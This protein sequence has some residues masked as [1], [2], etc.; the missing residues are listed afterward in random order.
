MY[1]VVGGLLMMAIGLGCASSSGSGD[2]V[3]AASEDAEMSALEKEHAQLRASISKLSHS[4]DEPDSKNE[5]DT[6]RARIAAEEQLLR[7]KTA[8]FRRRMNA[9]FAPRK[10]QAHQQAKREQLE[11][12][13][14]ELEEELA[15]IR[16]R[17]GMES[18]NA[19]TEDEGSVDDSAQPPAESESSPNPKADSDADAETALEA[20]R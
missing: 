1:R 2:G 12:E 18:T 10:N 4:I 6:F 14:D 19:S 8:G 9:L 7:E 13:V 11:R 3:E 5:E 16:E 17:S 15:R 20:D